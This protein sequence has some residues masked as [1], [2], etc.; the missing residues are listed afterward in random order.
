ML[1]PKTVVDIFG[2]DMV[3]QKVDNTIHWI[4][5]YRVDSSVCFVNIYMLDNDLSIG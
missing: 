3:A 4:N 5:P 1:L 2:Q